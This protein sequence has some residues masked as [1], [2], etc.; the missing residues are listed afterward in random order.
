M[1]GASATITAVAV[2]LLEFGML[3]SQDVWEQLRLYALGSAVVAGLAVATAADGH[4]EELYV[5]AGVTLALKAVVFPLGIAYVLRSL[6]AD[7]R[8][9]SVIGA[10][11]AVLAAIALSAFAFVALRDVHLG[12]V[13]AL[14]LSALPV[15][16]A[17][18]LVAFLLMV[19]RPYAPSQLVGFLV[20]EN[21][22]SVASL[23]IAPGLPLIL[24]LLLLF[25]VLVGVL[26]FVV[27][28]QY[29]AIERTAV[30]T[31]VLDG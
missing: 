17:G 11:T 26:V 23:V 10:P 6:D 29:L 18:I 16:V 30:R 25:D 28:V 2:L 12:G 14:P 1:F 15:A 22:V 5:L 7:P 4:G 27:L 8:V 13:P 19:V 3:R 20:L 21:A 24:A 31:D 9:P